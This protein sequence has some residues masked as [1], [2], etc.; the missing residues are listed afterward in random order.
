MKSKTSRELACH[1]LNRLEREPGFPEFHLERAFDASPGMEARD[2]AFVLNM[3]QGV[4]RWELRLDWMIQKK[5]RFPFRRISPDILN[6]LRIALYQILFMDRVPDS[7]AVDEAVKQAKK[8]AP[9]HVVRFVNGILRRICRE[10]DR[11][12]FPDP[13]KDLVFHLSVRHSYPP[14]L[15]EKWTRELGSGQTERLLEAGNRIPDLVLRTNR[16]KTDRG[17]LMRRL[18]GEGLSCEPTR[19]APDGVRVRHLGGSIRRLSAFEQGLFQVQGEAA[20]I[21]SY[22]LPCRAGDRVIDCCAGLGG[23]TTHLAELTEDQGFI[24][25]LD[26]A[27]DRLVGLT[28]TVKRLGIHGLF[29]IEGDAGENPAALF[30]TTFDRIL[31]DAPC[32]ALGTLARHPDVKWRRGPED[33]ARLSRVQGRLLDRVTPLLR[34][35]GHL[36]YATCTISREE[37]EGV[38]SAFLERHP[39]MVLDDLRGRA[40]AWTAPFLDERGMFRA[41]PHIHGT[42]GFFA[43]RFMKKTTG[44]S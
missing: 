18:E 28:H 42:E 23:K 44:S 1:I 34:P 14:W 27:H 9:P 12:V 30:K 33:V 5:A 26:R 3:V 22:L 25:A 21:C 4:L 32:S 11:P 24:V 17:T 29:P 20:Q 35:R 8:K 38:V 6:I 10:K 41:L 2:R 7:A 39:N 43:A 40:P 15:I 13:Q 16:L 19:F 31:V 37:N 36:I